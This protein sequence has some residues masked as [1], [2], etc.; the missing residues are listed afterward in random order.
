MK[1]ADVR[2]IETH[3]KR[4]ER[5]WLEIGEKIESH[6]GRDDWSNGCPGSLRDDSAVIQLRMGIVFTCIR[7]LWA[8]VCVCVYVR[9]FM[10]A[11]VMTVSC[12]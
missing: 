3:K 9:A 6:L 10:C 4:R 5:N 7:C 8:C 12:H 2:V 11:N 1:G